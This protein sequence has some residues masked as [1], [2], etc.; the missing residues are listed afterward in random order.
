MEFNEKLALELKNKYGLNQ[1]T[2][3][4]WQSRGTIPNKYLN[5]SFAPRRRLTRQEFDQQYRLNKVLK[6]DKISCRS[7]AT[8]CDLPYHTLVNA[9]NNKADYAPEVLG[10]I[11][12]HLNNLRL[13]IDRVVTEIQ[14]NSFISDLISNDLRKILTREELILR[15]ILGFYDEEVEENRVYDWR[16][17]KQTITDQLKRRIADKLAAFVL[18][19]AL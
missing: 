7:L 17:K 9:M 19:T 8:A 1:R 16:A 11:R 13:E 18:E 12:Q 4:V 2:V 3:A 5:E 6:L 15:N 14:K 10:T